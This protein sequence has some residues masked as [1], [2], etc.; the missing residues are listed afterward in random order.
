MAFLAAIEVDQ[1]QRIITSADK[2]KE[3]LGGS[4]TIEETGKL[5]KDVLGAQ[6][7]KVEA[8]KV[9]S[10]DIWL[11]AERLDDLSACLQEFRSEIVDRLNLP[12]SFALVEEQESP[13]ETRKTLMGKIRSVKDGKSGEVGHVSLPWLAPCQIQPGQYANLWFPDR[14]K[15]E[16]HRRRAL[17]SDD[18]DARFSRGMYTL[19]HYYQRFPSVRTNNL[20]IPQQMNHFSESQDDSY[21]ALLRFDADNAGSL[22]ERLYL[23]T[24]LEY[25]SWE[26]L[27]TCSEKFGKCITSA[28]NQVF[29][30]IIIQAIEENTLKKGKSWTPISPL[31]AAGDDLLLVIRKDLAMQFALGLLT[32]FRV[33]ITKA[34]LNDYRTET[35]AEKAITLSGA[36]VFARSGFPF[37]VLSEMSVIV[38]RSAKALRKQ[39]GQ[40]EPCLDV[41]WLESTGR[42]DPIQARKEALTYRAGSASTDPIYS[43]NTR[44][45]TLPQAAAM[46][47]AA[48]LLAEHDI[49]RGK[50]HQ[51]LA[52]LKGGDPQAAF[53][54]KSWLQHL[55][56]EQKDCMKK[57]AQLLEPVQ[58]WN[59]ASEPWVRNSENWLVTPLMEL[60]Q[61][62][63]MLSG[64]RKATE[65]IAEA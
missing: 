42:E 27:R 13:D 15:Q 59:F 55:G 63:E 56:E 39:G 45:W 37:S 9:A 52:G 29:E 16:Q 18:S 53:H 3:M 47:K 50:W 65:G 7:R 20:R 31:I 6:P 1:R 22:F 35:A 25:E 11:R 60:H 32:A 8:I 24:T 34:E 4:W 43:L 21:L 49:P 44:P 41:Y 17:V 33:E 40:T 57:V 36:V 26:P 48:E 28:F 58:L 2:L 62:R 46:Q 12:C 30:A 61:L 14:D 23:G 51:L 5:V 64:D 10:G 54:Y 38:E 19:G